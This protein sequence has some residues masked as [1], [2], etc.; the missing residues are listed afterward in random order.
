MAI[1]GILT[2][3]VTAQEADNDEKED[4]KVVVTGSQ[5][6]GVDLADAQ[7]LLTISSDDIKRS[8]ATSVSELLKDVGVFRGGE[9]SFNTSTSGALSTNTPAGM[10]A[11]TLR[12]L[13]ASSTLTLVNGRRIA[14][15]S[16]AA[17]NV[18]F[19][20]VNALP[21]AAIERI[22]VL[23][24][25]ASAIY[26]AD[27]VAGVVNYILKEDYEGFE[28]SASYGN[29]DADTDESKSSV[30]FTYGAND[31]DSNFLVTLDYY[32]R[33]AFKYGD[34]EQTAETFFPVFS[35][36]IFPHV[37]FRD[38][39]TGFAEVD[40]ACPDDQV[41][42][43]PEFGDASCAFDPNPYLDVYAPV[44]VLST[45]LSYRQELDDE[46]SFF[47]ELIYSSKESEASSSPNR[48]RGINDSTNSVFV[49]V[50]HPG[51]LATPTTFQDLVDQS[52][53]DFRIRGRFEAPR[54]IGIETDSLHLATG[55]EGMIDEWD[56]EAA[57]T[58]SENESTQNALEG[59]YNRFAFNAALFGELCSD[60]TTNCAP[61]VDG[62]Y[63]N[64]FGG[65]LGNEQALALMEEAVTRQG[66]S[67]VLGIDLKFS[68][69]LMEFGNDVISMASGIEFRKEKITDNPSELAVASAE[70]GY[71]PDVLGF[72]SSRVSAERDQYALFAEFFIPFSDQFSV[73][74]AGRYDH[75]DNFG[76]DFNPKI[77]FRWSP[78]EDLVV[79]G[80]WSTSF[81]A[82]SLS[83]AGVDLRTTSFSADCTSNISSFCAGQGTVGGFSLEIGNPDLQPE[84]S[85][86]ISYGFAWS[87]TDDIT[88]T[89]DAWM[90]DHEDI[91]DVDAEG[92]IF[93]ALNNPEQFAYCGF[94]PE[95]NVGI[96]IDTEWC[97]YY[98]VPEGD[99][100]TAGE[101]ADSIAD[102]E[103]F[104]NGDA[105][106]VNSTFQL[107]NIGSQKVSGFDMTY[108]QY[109]DTESAG[110]FTVLFDSTYLDK[111]ERSRTLL[112]NTEQLAGSFRYPRI[113]ASLKLR[114]SQDDLFGSISANY[115][116]KYRDEIA[117]LGELNADPNDP[118]DY[119]A[120]DYIR[121]TVGLDAV[122]SPDRDVPSW[123]TVNMEFGKDFGDDI[124]VR[125]GINNLF[126]ED[127]PFVYGRY[128]NADMLNHDVMGRYYR[129]TY[130][131]R[132]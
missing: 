29:S 117:E 100:L 70:N 62:I 59:I 106:G 33:N 43:D 37:N 80:S 96:V 75:Y 81:R 113:V 56:W 42:F 129:L 108:T 110:R 65:Q 72:G 35:G 27:A 109:I 101:L 131:Q 46:T 16:F 84:T 10:A 48:F 90:F 102:A 73:Q 55:F 69:E 8:N 130:T 39:L 123:T 1:S 51:F 118:T 47:A 86:S 54:R 88:I 82:P 124:T 21:L 103:I 7:P 78:I 76:G 99:N 93:Q 122:P 57:L 3:G 116:H 6:K 49:P 30:S 111:F 18:N 31:D 95:G 107:Q 15:S 85:E 22:E 41:Y 32:D 74:L 11:A 125:F 83:Q 28:I 50:D 60:G 87:P 5:I 92:L 89:A 25:G 97:G 114:W 17:G 20:D 12:G 19:V 128:L 68:G 53:G 52:F 67:E 9:G 79:R 63:F 13:G 112:S 132:F 121:D 119:D 26:G 61:G 36:G 64:P 66:K 2:L 126:D 94:V 115:T 23:P 105:L 40:P 104:G 71:I 24:T 77:G 127:A 58:Y 91:I 34:R 44:E 45:S 14:A 38:T 98:G 120:L 4:N